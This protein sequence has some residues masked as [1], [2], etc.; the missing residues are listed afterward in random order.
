V[1]LAAVLS[2]KHVADRG[3][4]AAYSVSRHPALLEMERDWVGAGFFIVVIYGPF[5]T[6]FVFSPYGLAVELGIWLLVIAVVPAFWFI[7][8][9]YQL[10]RMLSTLKQQHLSHA[11]QT[12]QKLAK[13]VD[14]DASP[15]TLAELGVAM[16]IEARI[17]AMPEWPSSFMGISGLVLALIPI[18][19]QIAIASLGFGIVL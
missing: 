1:V 14:D 17:Q 5:L 10:N 12:V 9:T 19:I 4:S 3:L 6:A 2:V 18:V 11:S 16:E 8:G 7:A 15:I 13:A